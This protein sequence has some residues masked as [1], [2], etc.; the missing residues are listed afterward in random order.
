VTIEEV[1]HYRSLQ[2]IL[3]DTRGE[4]QNTL[5]CRGR[6]GKYE[7]TFSKCVKNAFTDKGY[8]YLTA[9]IGRQINWRKSKLMTV[10]LFTKWSQ[11]H[12]FLKHIYYISV[13]K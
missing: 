1:L 9:K 3:C 12:V 7:I 13:M 5:A 4:K 11:T 6:A 10:V 8:L 2:F